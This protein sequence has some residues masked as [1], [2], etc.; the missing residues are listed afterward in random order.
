MWFR[1]Y[2]AQKKLQKIYTGRRI[3]VGSKSVGRKQNFF[4]YFLPLL[5]LRVGGESMGEGIPTSLNLLFF[6]I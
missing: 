6:I 4:F 3:E 1:K 5:L 2:E